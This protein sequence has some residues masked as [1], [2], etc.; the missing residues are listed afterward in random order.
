MTESQMIL[1]KFTHLLDRLSGQHV[2]VYGLGGHTEYALSHLADKSAIVGLMDAKRVGET[3][4]GLRVY[5][6][7]EI[8]GIANAIVIVARDAV[9]RLIYDRIKHLEQ[10]GITI[11]N[12]VGDNLAEKFKAADKEYEDNPYWD[13]SLEQ[14]KATVAT[15]DV[16]S[17]DIFDTLLMRR[18]IRPHEE[19]GFETEKLLNVPRR[20][21]VECMDYALSLGKRVFILSDMYFSSQQLGELLTLNGISGYEEVIV[22]C[23]YNQTK[24]S[25]ELY[26]ILK[27][28]AGSVSILHIGDNLQADV[29]NAKAHGVD[30]FFVMSA[31][32]ML[33]NSPMYELLKDVLTVGDSRMIGEFAANVL[34]SPFALCAE[35]GRVSINDIRTVTSYFAPIVGEFL[36]YLVRELKDYGDDTLVLFLAR[37]GWIIKR[38]YDWMNA[39]FSLNMPKSIYFLASRIAVSDKYADYRGNYCKYAKKLGVFAYERVIAYDLATKG[40]TVAKLTENFGIPIEL[41]CFASFNINDKFSGGMTHSLLGDFSYYDLSYNFLRLYE[42]LE[43][44]SFPHKTQFL[45]IDNNLNA[46]YAPQESENG[47]E[48]DTIEL[49]Q[50]CLCESIKCS[51]RMPDWLNRNICV[52]TADNILGLIGTRYATAGEA[53]K[54]AFVFD[55]PL[56]SVMPTAWWDRLVM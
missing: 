17:F 1:F 47:R 46:V 28:K 22:S 53:V 3:V 32:D 15:H 23:E 43:I 45:C 24:E 31:Y 39:E 30:T 9:M 50:N 25:G 34:N 38:L 4:F 51:A 16:I 8:V 20:D 49:F 33:L 10:N 18:I 5:G 29:K 36:R 2:A 6:V 44:M 56:E 27:S 52:K 37:D 41:I 7:D 12:V 19:L 54:S 48:W 21:M 40:T 14:L 13:S 26:E 35:R 42:L 11:F 55:S